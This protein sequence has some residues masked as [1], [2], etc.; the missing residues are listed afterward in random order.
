MNR[1]LLRRWIGEGSWLLA[2]CAIALFAFCWLRIWVIGQIEM[3]SFQVILE[4]VWEKYEK[5]SPVPLS[6][7]LTYHGRVAM[8]FAEPLVVLCLAVW[9][10]AR[11]SDCVSGHL[12]R[13]VMEMLLAQPIRR[14]EII[15][16]QS[17][18]TVLGIGLLCLCV[19]SGVWMGIQTTTVKEERAQTMSLPGLGL[20]VPIP[21]STPELVE[22]PMSE[23]TSANY[24]IYPTLNLFILSFL[25]AGLAT[26]LSSG[27][28]YRWRTIGI[29]SGLVVLQMMMRVLCLASEP[30]RWMAYLTIF[31]AYVPELLVSIAVKSPQDL[32]RVLLYDDQGVLTGPGPLG[33]QLVLLIPGIICFGTATWI[34]SRRD[35]PAPL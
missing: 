13:G 3:G 17:L 5:Y 20:K 30:L 8:A 24:Y 14:W 23:R 1:T 25:L 10:I 35:L 4:Q 21:F 18:V 22:V 28:R 26:L 29:I 27:D 11:G 33:Y 9:A 32:W 34:F 19:W 15:L 16:S 6:Q 12:G 2:A 31:S 7:L